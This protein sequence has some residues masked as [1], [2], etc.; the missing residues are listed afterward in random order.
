M[1]RSLCD[2][3][4]TLLTVYLMFVS[5]TDIQMDYRWSFDE[6]G[7]TT[8]CQR[9]CEQHGNCSGY[10]FHSMMGTEISQHPPIDYANYYPDNNEN[11]TE[12]DIETIS[13]GHF[14]T[15][16]KT[17]PYQNILSDLVI[18]GG[19]VEEYFKDNNATMNGYNETVLQEIESEETVDCPVLIESQP[20]DWQY[21]QCG[22][23]CGSPYRLA[24]N[25]S[26]NQLTELSVLACEQ[27]ESSR[28]YDLLSN[29]TE[30]APFKEMKQE[31][32]KDQQVARM[33]LCS[34]SE[35]CH[36]Y[37]IPKEA[38]Q[39]EH[40]VQVDILQEC[41][42]SSPI[43][44]FSETVDPFQPI[45]EETKSVIQIH[46]AEEVQC[47]AVGPSPSNPEPATDPVTSKLAIGPYC[48]AAGIFTIDLNLDVLPHGRNKLPADQLKNGIVFELH[49]HM[50][51]LK[52]PRR[53]LV[54]VLSSLFDVPCLDHEDPRVVER[55]FRRAIQPLRAQRIELVK[56]YALS[57][58]RSTSHSKWRLRN[59]YNP[60]LIT[61]F[62]STVFVVPHIINEKRRYVTK[63][64]NNSKEPKSRERKP[65]QAQQLHEL[66]NRFD[67][68]RHAQR[69]HNAAFLRRIYS[70]QKELDR[71]RGWP[72][73]WHPNRRHP[74]PKATT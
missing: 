48:T 33:D 72:K 1:D 43:Q 45:S 27:S 12:I 30:N 17:Q 41:E 59:T 19:Q 39:E 50:L 69:K 8:L 9:H 20:D 10:V 34:I 7:T 5:F 64:N 67:A 36:P 46:S 73:H 25:N 74:T 66:Q 51:N 2:L 57:T 26:Q 24:V 38:V 53:L 23:N 44:A 49:T 15:E 40:E 32:P 42:V 70:V 18:C 29:P 31:S 65:T 52:A 28:L 71:V 16:F 60:D 11:Q 62:D 3:Q 55:F 58:S 4:H 14:E 56:R 63:V 61:Q 13:L 21:V 47:D 37:G 54:S 6:D 35:A 22:E 68:F